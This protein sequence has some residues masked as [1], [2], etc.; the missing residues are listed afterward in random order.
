MR[1]YDLTPFYRST[2]GFDRLFNL[3]DQSSAEA[4][5][6]YPPYNI[7]RTGDNAYRITVA[8]SGF[9][10]DELS[11]VAKE[12]TLTI[13]GEKSVSDNKDKSEVLYR[14]IAARAFE[15]VFQL[16]D[17]VQVK[18][19]SLEHGLLHVDLVREIPEA[20]KPRQI[21]ITSGGQPVNAQVTQVA[22]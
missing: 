21:A 10:Q 20:K 16:A 13:K 5:P 9:S 14:G 6:G 8:V 11:I 22:A 18:N 12:N 15:R 1:T 19:A 17:Y 3:L 2:I 4:A 7:E